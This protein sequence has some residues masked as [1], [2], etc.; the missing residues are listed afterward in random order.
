MADKKVTVQVD[1]D[2][3]DSKVMELE[4]EINR[5]KRERIQLKIDAKN[6]EIENIDSQINRLKMNINALAKDKIPINMDLGAIAEAQSKIDALEAEKAQLQ[7]DVAMDEVYKAKAEEQALNTTAHVDIDVDEQAVQGAMQNIQDGINNVKQGLSEVANGMA[8]TLESAGRMEQTETFLSMNLG[9]DKAKSKLEEI[10]AVTDKLPGDD[11]ALQNLLSQ[12]AIKDLKLGS[13]EFEEMGSNAADYMAAMQNFG[14]SSTETQQDLMNYI[15]AGNTAEIERSPIL[16][17]HIDK[18]KEGNTIQERSKLLGEALNA[19]HW[20]GIA[21]Q[22]TYNNKLQTFSDLIER[23]KMNF[24]GMFL[25]VTKGA[26]GFIGELDSATGGVLGMGAALATE[27]GPGLFQGAQGLVSMGAGL[28]T[29]GTEFG[30]IIPMLSH[31]AGEIPLIGGALSGLSLGPVALA[32]AA[33]VALGVAVFEVGKAFGWWSDLGTMFDAISTG[34]GEIWNSFMSN[35]YVIQIIDLIKQGLTDAW[36]AIVGFGQAI[37]TAIGGSGGQFDILSFAIQGL[38]TVL[39]VVGPIAIL[40]IQ[41][42]MNNFRTLYQVGQ[43]VWPYISA[44]IS[45]NIAVIRGVI[46]GAMAIWSGLQSAWHNLQSTASSVFGAINGI[47]S[48]AAGVWHSF[49]SSVQGV[50]DGIMDKINQLKDAAAGVANLVGLGG[51]GI[52]TTFNTSGGYG[53]NSYSAGNTFIFNMYGDVKDEKTLNDMITA[54]DNHLQFES[55]AN[56]GTVNNNGGAI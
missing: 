42:M 14:K 48:G 38:Q 32:I 54:I 41:S 10:R 30:G 43:M 46:G 21:S 40:Y 7:L 31:F 45:S 55:L 13:K 11:V 15:L 51:G 29:M 28:S 52:E 33:L 27:F 18:L 50:I 8:D 16:Q 23:G 49:Q 26:M 17:A 4:Q 36:N 34:L 20:K 25:D 2:V 5:I 44:V 22:D 24:G 1:T 6:E 9:A 39:S 37:M 47:V 35:E 3:N 12:S 56:G 19:E 53:G